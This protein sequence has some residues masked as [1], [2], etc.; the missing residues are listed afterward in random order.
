MEH[1]GKALSPLGGLSNFANFIGP[2]IGGLVSNYSTAQNGFYIQLGLTALTLLLVCVVPHQEANPNEEVTKEE[3][4]ELNGSQEE[5]ETSAELIEPKEKSE[6]C[7]ERTKEV[8]Q[9]TW[10]GLKDIL[11]LQ[12]RL[13]Q[14]N[15]RK[16]FVIGT[17]CCFL[18]F[19]RSARGLVIPLVAINIG[20][21]N[22]QVGL[23]TSIAFGINTLFCAVGG[24]VIDNY[25]RKVAGT[26]AIL[27]MALGFLPLPFILN[28]W[29]LVLTSIFAGIGN[30]FGSGLVLTMGADIAPDQNRSEFLGIF[31]F[32]VNLGSVIGPLLLG[33]LMDHL[34]L[35]GACGVIV[36]VG[37]LGAVW[38]LCFVEETLVKKEQKID[39]F[40]EEKAT[41]KSEEEED[42]DVDTDIS[43]ETDEQSS[44]EDFSR[45]KKV[46]KGSVQEIR[47]GL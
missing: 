30:S 2:I 10:D 35:E 40:P 12:L 23:V 26:I 38:L 41:D 44:E 14:E 29:G 22:T 34:P 15:A 21:S 8:F 39:Q 13:I 5:E 6:A 18:A 7:T 47:D 37:V 43:I 9:S 27:V 17:F 42:T 24:Y 31:R 46:L 4:T 11:S 19:V 1:R 28:I 33:A 25:G 32:A 20:L 36:G 3:V 16:L 45:L